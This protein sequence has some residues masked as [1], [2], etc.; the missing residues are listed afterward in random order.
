LPEAEAKAEVENPQQVV[1]N[2]SKVDKANLQKIMQKSSGLSSQEKIT[3][4]QIS[5]MVDG[6]D[7]IPKH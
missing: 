1:K 4:E 7:L 3:T 6:L 2:D 5:K